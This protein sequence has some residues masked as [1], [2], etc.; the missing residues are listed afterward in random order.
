MDSKALEALLINDIMIGL[1]GFFS[2]S[3]MI[4]DSEVRNSSYY[5]LPDRELA[6][7]LIDILTQNITIKLANKDDPN[8]YKVLSFLRIT[9]VYYFEYNISGIPVAVTKKNK[10]D[11]EVIF[12]VYGYMPVQNKN[13]RPFGL[14]KSDLIRNV[15][16][17]NKR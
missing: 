4:S 16:K 10:N 12:T 17:M 7:M 13:A 6:T 3:N 14:K 15:I 9:S 5:N 8:V 11:K 1:E 2:N